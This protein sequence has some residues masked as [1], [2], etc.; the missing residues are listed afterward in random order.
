MVRAV[1]GRT[2]TVPVPPIIPWQEAVEG[3]QQIVIG[4]G[5]DLHDHETGGRMWH[6]DRQQALGGTDVD[7]ERST[8][9]SEVRQAAARPRPDGQLAGVYGKMLRRASRNRPRPP[10]AGADS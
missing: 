1:A 2:M 10:R 3:G 9:G 8:F 4:P 5:A 7:E 6:E